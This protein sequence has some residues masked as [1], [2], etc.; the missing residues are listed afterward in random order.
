MKKNPAKI[1]DFCKESFTFQQGNKHKKILM[2][3]DM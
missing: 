2:L 3:F 1:G